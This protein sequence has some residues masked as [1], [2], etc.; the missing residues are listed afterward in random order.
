MLR[1]VPIFD[2]TAVADLGYKFVN[3]AEGH[4]KPFAWLHRLAEPIAG[5][6]VEARW[7]KCAM[8]QAFQLRS[9][10]VVEPVLC[11]N[12]DIGEKK[13]WVITCVRDPAG[14]RLASHPNLVD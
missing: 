10:D 7:S 12:V 11:D 2:D 9:V 1:V 3:G 6:K 5:R 13:R 8:D 14:N 4:K